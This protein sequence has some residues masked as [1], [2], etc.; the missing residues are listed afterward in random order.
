M[1][2]DHLPGAGALG[3]ISALIDHNPLVNRF[4]GRKRFKGGCKENYDLCE[5]IS[6]WERFT[7]WQEV[8]K[9]GATRAE[10]NVR[11]RRMQRFYLTETAD[12]KTI[13]E[14]QHRA[15]VIGGVQTLGWMVDLFC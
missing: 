2:G 7:K 11:I 1:R 10:R 3:S 12:E 9:N 13:H 14:Q 4:L 8:R 15:F 6:W 5:L